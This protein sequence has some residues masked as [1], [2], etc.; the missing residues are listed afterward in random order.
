MSFIV[1]ESIFDHRNKHDHDERTGHGRSSA[2][3]TDK[4]NCLQEAYQ[5]EVPVGKLAEL[6]NKIEA[7]EVPPLVLG[8]LDLITYGFT[9]LVLALKIEI[10]VPSFYLIL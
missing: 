3:D 5:K 10:N 8:G 4:L 7:Q 2:R 6:G 1:F 9:I